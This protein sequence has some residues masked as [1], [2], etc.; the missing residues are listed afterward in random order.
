MLGPFQGTDNRHAERTQKPRPGVIAQA[1]E[2]S[3]LPIRA[4][5]FQHRG[6][7]GGLSGTAG[8]AAS[9]MR[10]RAAQASRPGARPSPVQPAVAGGLAGVVGAAACC[11]IAAIT[12]ATEAVRR[13]A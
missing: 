13:L 5:G 10:W 1:S 4:R 9:R 6:P 12:C 11:A 7:V 3:S 8:A 2:K